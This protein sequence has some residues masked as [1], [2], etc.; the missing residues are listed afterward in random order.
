MSYTIS[1][2]NFI[3]A[4]F[5]PIIF[6]NTTLYLYNE[7]IRV[8]RGTDYRSVVFPSIIVVDEMCSSIMF[9]SRRFRGTY[10]ACVI[11]YE[12]SD[13]RRRVFLFFFFAFRRRTFSWKLAAPGAGPFRVRTIKRS[14][15]LVDRNPPKI[16]DTRRCHKCRNV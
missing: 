8:A 14:H 13:D 16:I 11:E 4:V 12:R 9:Q 10:A 6:I 5:G 3:S 2:S 1:K 7:T 15:T